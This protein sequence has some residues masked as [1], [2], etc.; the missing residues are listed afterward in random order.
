MGRK[1]FLK[2]ISFPLYFQPHYFSTETR[3]TFCSTL[4]SHRP[5][6]SLLPSSATSQGVLV[7][8]NTGTCTSQ[9]DDDVQTRTSHGCIRMH[10][11]I[12]NNNYQSSHNLLDPC[13]HLK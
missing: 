5:F 13:Y 7:R 1:L 11:G 2:I 10:S 12:T 4:P 8:W 9:I 3:S 6:Y